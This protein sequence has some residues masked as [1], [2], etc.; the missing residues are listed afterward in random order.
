MW[1]EGKPDLS[2]PA[3]QYKACEALGICMLYLDQCCFGDMCWYVHVCDHQLLL[4]VSPKTP[5]RLAAFACLSCPSWDTA[6]SWAVKTGVK[7]LQ[8]AVLASDRFYVLKV[9]ALS[10]FVNYVIKFE[11][12][13]KYLEK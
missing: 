1:G 5:G 3:V 10:N 11:L 9:I 8:R 4:W 6:P 13:A 12:L 7:V 2:V